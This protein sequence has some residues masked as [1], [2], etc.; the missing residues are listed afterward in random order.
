MQSVGYYT[1]K[2]RDPQD[3]FDFAPA[4]LKAPQASAAR[5]LQPLTDWFHRIESTQT[6]PSKAETAICAA[7]ED[8]DF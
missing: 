5:A 6:T 8:P 3:S 4:A 7:Q 1:W 2:A